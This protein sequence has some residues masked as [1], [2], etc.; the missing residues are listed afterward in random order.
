MLTEL[1]VQYL[2]YMGEYKCLQ[3]LNEME[4]EGLEEITLMTPTHWEDG[5]F[6]FAAIPLVY[7]F[8]DI[9]PFARKGVTVLGKRYI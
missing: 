6:T 4:A 2:K 3:Y 7:G 9:V 8:K 1:K 5:V